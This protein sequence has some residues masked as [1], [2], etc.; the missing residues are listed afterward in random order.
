MT[1]TVIKA[2]EIDA[3]VISE[4]ATK[5]WFPAYSD[6]LST[7]QISFMLRDRYSVTAL[8]SAM[9]Q[10][11]DFFLL[12]EDALYLG[13]ISLRTKDSKTLRIEKLYV[14]QEQQGKSYGR[15]LLG[16]AETEAQKL[17]CK[18]IELNVN[19]KN[20]AVGF[21]KKQGFRIVQE[22]DIPYADFIL[23]DYVMQQSIAKPKQPS[24]LFFPKI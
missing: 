23:D 1:T 21:Y 2:H 12:K 24:D 10:G 20:S 3:Q 16:F 13:F 11:E 5:I 15:Q 18:K 6:I 4:L 22:V 17:G 9:R 8:C 7:Q 19:R 14:L